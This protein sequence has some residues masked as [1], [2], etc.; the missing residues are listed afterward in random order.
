MNSSADDQKL[1]QLATVV[2]KMA[3]QRAAMNARAVKMH[4]DMMKHMMQHMEAGSES[5]SHCPMMKGMSH[6]DEKVARTP[7]AHHEPA[8]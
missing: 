1:R 6:T 5:V 4:D 3:E 8:K 7:K 2:T